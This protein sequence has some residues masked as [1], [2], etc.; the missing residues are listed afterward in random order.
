MHSL[1]PWYIHQQCQ[2]EEKLGKAQV[3]QQ[4]V[5]AACKQGGQQGKLVMESKETFALLLFVH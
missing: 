1:V 3:L 4:M 2:Q 5:A